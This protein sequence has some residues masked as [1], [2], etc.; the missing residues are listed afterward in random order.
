MTKC[1]HEK[2]MQ[3]QKQEKSS[4]EF[5]VK[6][7]FKHDGRLA[8]MKKY[9][10]SERVFQVLEGTSPCFYE[11]VFNL[12]NVEALEVDGDDRANL[13]ISTP[14]F[15]SRDRLLWQTCHE[16]VAYYWP[17]VMDICQAHLALLNEEPV[18]IQN[19]KATWILELELQPD[20]TFGALFRLV[21]DL[22][23]FFKDLM[24]RIQ[25]EIE[26][27]EGVFEFFQR[28]NS[29]S[30]LEDEDKQVEVKN[31]EI[32]IPYSLAR[33]MEVFRDLNWG[34]IITQYLQEIIESLEKER[35]IDEFDDKFQ[36]F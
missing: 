13:L 32:P 21:E 17:H 27:E 25:L 10:S 28:T 18:E 3:V 5:V 1:D 35:F 26:F 14:V 8:G 29:F 16:M 23:S 11:I 24:K 36:K 15:R 2:I 22:S 30:S 6:S 9:P 12:E 33:R 20:I 4:E 7:Y 19:D 34:E 31:L